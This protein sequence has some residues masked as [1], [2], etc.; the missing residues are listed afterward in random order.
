[1]NPIL[2]WRIHFA[3]WQ[4]SLLIF[5]LIWSTFIYLC[6]RTGLLRWILTNNISRSVDEL[7]RYFSHVVPPDDWS[8][9]V[10]MC[11]LDHSVDSLQSTPVQWVQFSVMYSS[12][13]SR[14]VDLIYALKLLN[15]S[16]SCDRW[17][18]LLNSPRFYL[19][20]CLRFVS[21]VNNRHVG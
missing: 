19:S 20:F 4:S 9:Y 3:C 17:M 18:C 6:L 11:V 12:L 16:G 15:W 8:G 14:S 2:N 1:M 5:L 13:A 21:S 7:S 10:W